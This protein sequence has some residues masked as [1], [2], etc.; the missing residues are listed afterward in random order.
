M[1]T[2]H[3]LYAHPR[4]HTRTMQL[5]V[6]AGLLLVIGSAAACAPTQPAAADDP[7]RLFYARFVQAAPTDA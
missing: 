1:A 7:R 4:K 5:K 3:P 6:A 2:V